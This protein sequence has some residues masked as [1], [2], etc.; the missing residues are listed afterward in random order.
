V[1]GGVGVYATGL[2]DVAE[3][4]SSDILLNKT[5]MYACK[6]VLWVGTAVVGSF[7][8]ISF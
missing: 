6:K 5:A 8:E 7:F 2:A 4:T 3:L 1:E